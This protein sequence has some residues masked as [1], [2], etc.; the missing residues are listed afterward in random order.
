MHLTCHDTV[1]GVADMYR[2]VSS[3]PNVKGLFAISGLRGESGR[4]NSSSS[5]SCCSRIGALPD[6][7]EF[8]DGIELKLG[9]GTA[10]AGFETVFSG[11][12]CGSA[13]I[14]GVALFSSK[15]CD[16]GEIGVGKVCNF[17]PFSFSDNLLPP[18]LKGDNGTLGSEFETG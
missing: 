12:S 8:I 3:I 5:S 9:G 14:T 11:N 13:A 10:A 17:N 6:S 2:F 7:T 18:G 4:A 1:V 15:V 16:S